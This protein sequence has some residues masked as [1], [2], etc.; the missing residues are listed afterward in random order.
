M[1]LRLCFPMRTKGRLN[2]IHVWIVR[3]HIGIGGSL[4]APPSHTTQHTGPYCAVRLIK[5]N[6]TRENKYDLY[7]GHIPACLSLMIHRHDHW[8]HKQSIGHACRIT[9]VVPLN[10]LEPILFRRA[11]RLTLRNEIF[12]HCC[13]DSIRNRPYSPLSFTPA[14]RQVA[15][16]GPSPV[17]DLHES[18]PFR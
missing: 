8:H 7:R 1:K 18:L 9:H 15:P 6:R 12:S 14:I 4:A 10:Y 17:W 3:W 16:F 5:R 13:N 2:E 11:F